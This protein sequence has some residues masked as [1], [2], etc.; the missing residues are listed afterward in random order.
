MFVNSA[1][2]L[3][4]HGKMDYS[5]HL[6]KCVCGGHPA[7][8]LVLMSNQYF[9]VTYC[10][11]CPPHALHGCALLQPLLQTHKGEGVP[12]GGDGLPVVALELTGC[13]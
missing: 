8:Y 4:P 2:L 10:M 12:A 6:R 3:K 5:G 11:L 1:C 7:L 9:A 13:F